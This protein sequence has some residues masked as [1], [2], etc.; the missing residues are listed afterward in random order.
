MCSLC[1]SSSNLNLNGFSSKII[2]Y[3]AAGRENSWNPRSCLLTR[4]PICENWSG[5]VMH[6]ALGSHFTENHLFCPFWVLIKWKIHFLCSI[7]KKPS[8]KS[9]RHWKDAHLCQKWGQYSKVCYRACINQAQL[10]RK[11]SEVLF[12]AIFCVEFFSEMLVC[13]VLY[14]F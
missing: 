8:Y 3:M 13:H 9:C 11:P 4:S 1:S 7:S 5:G 10:G 14:F 12:G 2:Q 6:T